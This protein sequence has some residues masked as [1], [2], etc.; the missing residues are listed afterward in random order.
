MTNATYP[1][2]VAV[3]L[4]DH[5]LT[6]QT[7]DRVLLVVYLWPK[8]TPRQRVAAGAGHHSLTPAQLLEFV[9]PLGV[10]A[11]AWARETLARRGWEVPDA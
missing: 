4:G 6:V 10:P 11:G 1:I 3:V 7:G 5:E 2:T 9:A 8:R